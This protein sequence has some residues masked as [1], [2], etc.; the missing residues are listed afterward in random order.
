PV[1]PMPPAT[2]RPADISDVKWML[3][4]WYN[5]T[6]TSGDSLLEQAVHSVDKIAWAMKDQPPISAVASGGRAV[7]A[8]GGNIFDHFNV[9]YEYPEGVRAFLGCRQQRNCHGENADYI[10]GTKGR[11]TIGSGPARIEGE[12]MFRYRGK[13]KS[14]YQVEHDE[15]FA[16]IR[17]GKPMNDGWMAT[18]T[19]LALMGRMAAYT[20]KKITW[21]QALNSTEDLA[22]D[23]VSWDSEFDVH[24][25]AI[26]GVTKFS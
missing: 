23:L 21:E 20:G 17:A 22:P 13:K 26:P 18:S 19:L 1:K 15:L 16:S 10:L 24:P 11:C 4:N 7:A 2:K 14:M 12:D 25:L 3:Q 6:W 5:F 8:E 9:N